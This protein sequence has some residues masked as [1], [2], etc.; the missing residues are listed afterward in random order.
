MTK[1]YEE[2][3]FF[4]PTINFLSKFI[5]IIENIKNSVKSPAIDLHL[6]NSIFIYK[7]LGKIQV[8]IPNI[9]NS[10]ENFTLTQRQGNLSEKLFFDK[11][12]NLTDFTLKIYLVE[13]PPFYSM[14]FGLVCPFCSFAKIIH[15]YLKPKIE[16]FELVTSEEFNEIGIIS[17]VLKANELKK[18]PQIYIMFFDTLFSTRMVP[19]LFVQKPVKMSYFVTYPPRIPMYEQI[20]ILPLD[21]SVWMLLFISTGCCGLIWRLFKIFGEG[22]GFWRFIFVAYGQLL[23]KSVNIKK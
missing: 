19:L 16:V 8:E 15:Q 2:L 13:S 23:G 14:K 17:A 21:R 6:V 11:F 9:L 5:F 7:K 18:T 3:Y 22:D 4:N 10:Y 1:A 20:L 12:K